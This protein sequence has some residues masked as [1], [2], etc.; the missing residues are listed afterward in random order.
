MPRPVPFHHVLLAVFPFLFLFTHNVGH[1]VGD[2]ALGLTLAMTLSGAAALALGWILGRCAGDARRGAALASL[3]ALAVF[4]Y[5]HV[6]NLVDGVTVGGM[7]LG[8]HLILLPVWGLAFLLAGVLVARAPGDLARLTG[9]ANAVAIALVLMSAFQLAAFEWRRGGLGAAGVASPV[10]PAAAPARGGMRPDIYYVILDGYAGART[11]AE[12][13]DFDNEAFL[14]ALRQRGFYVATDSASNY[15]MTFLSLASSLNMTYVHG[16]LDAR[17]E[18]RSFHLLSSGLRDNAVLRFVRERGYQYIHFRSG[19]DG[20][21][22]YNPRA[23]RN[24]TCGGLSEFWM[25]LLQTTLFKPLEAR[26]GRVAEDARQ[27]I[28]C[29]FDQLVEVARQPGPKLVFAHILVPHPPFLFDAEG[30]PVAPPV[31]ALTGSEV[32]K[33]RAGYLAQLRFT[34]RRLLEAIDRLREVSAA[35]P[36][37]VVQGDHGPGSIPWW[38]GGRQLVRERMFIL[39]AYQLPGR[40]AAPLYPTISPVNTF[41]L[42]FNEYF[43]A[44]LPLL[45]DEPFFSNGQTPY[46]FENVSGQLR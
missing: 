45:P 16:P 33:D 35:P 27:R 37:I 11:L 22:D 5:G 30:R 29:E 15:A 21:T 26:V 34:N 2:R 1:S 36:V 38:Q 13:Y 14:A 19:V 4:T 39:N 44:R 9:G 42:I 7:L 31:L 46:A 40:P 3:V 24:I 18:A 41:R 8:R 6:H 17:D 20:L 12:L 25:L 32:W 10:P 43:D 23:D 28:L